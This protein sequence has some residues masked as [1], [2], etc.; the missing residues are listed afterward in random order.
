ML[1]GLLGGFARG[2][3][4]TSAATLVLD[5]LAG[6]NDSRITYSGGAN[7]T[8]VNSSGVIVAATTPRFDYD[9]VTLAAKGL[10][11]EEARTNL[12]TYSEQF[13]NAAWVKAGASI[14]A[15]AVVA[16]SGATTA[17]KLV[18]SA[19]N[20]THYVYE[21]ITQAANTTNSITVYAKAAERSY[22]GLQMTP[23]G[24]NYV[25]CTFNVSTGTASTP[26]NLGNGSGAVASI[27]PAGN[28]WY[29]CSLSGIAS[30]TAANPVCA[31]YVGSTNANFA[32]SPYLGDGTSGVYIWGAQ[33]EAGSFPTSYIPTTSAS[34]TRT[35]DSAVM[36][37]TN[38]SSWYN[39]SEGTFVVSASVNYTAPANSD[40]SCVISADD[41]TSSNRIQYFRANNSGTPFA[42]MVV[43]AGGAIA[44]NINAGLT[45]LQPGKLAGA[46]AANNFAAS[47]NGLTLVTDV[48]GNVPTVTQLQIGNGAALNALNGHIRTLQYFP[49]RLPNTQLQTLTA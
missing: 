44:A 10:L 8:R 9:P 25:Y 5:F 34:V 36:T 1:R 15:N 27:T 6:L 48:S 2:R 20:A 41:G 39:Q 24:A 19:A 45:Q 46:Y 18:E 37:G 42:G 47:L 30:S 3:R 35:A 21:V 38:F 28:G 26:V 12:F 14:S 43:V 17:D 40:I 33:L 23:D 13:D 11:V 31:I 32:S 29:R 49:R 4:Q 16:P 22:I 7:G